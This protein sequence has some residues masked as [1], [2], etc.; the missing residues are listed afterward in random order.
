MSEEEDDD[1]AAGG[2]YRNYDETP[3]RRP[4]VPQGYKLGTAVLLDFVYTAN[5]NLIDENGAAVGTK[6][7]F[8]KVEGVV[9]RKDFY[10]TWIDIQIGDDILHITPEF[11]SKSYLGM[12]R[13]A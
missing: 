6:S 10:D 11:I 13:E 12:S 8:G 7:F 1:K 2:N 3:V 9:V 4:Q 5:A